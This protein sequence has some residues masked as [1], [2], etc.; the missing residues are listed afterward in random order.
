LCK[1]GIWIGQKAGEI[2]MG[3]RCIRH[4][5]TLREGKALAQCFNVE[6]N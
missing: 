4:N 5:A 1:R 3:D 2:N 6:L